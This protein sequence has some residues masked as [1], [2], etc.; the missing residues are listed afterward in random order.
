MEFTDDLAWLSVNFSQIADKSRRTQ[1]DMELTQ[2]QTH[3]VFDNSSSVAGPSRRGSRSKS[4]DHFAMSTPPTDRP[5]NGTPS[6]IEPDTR[7][8]DLNET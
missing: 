2:T 7:L 8:R 1:P 3:D 5:S 6:E 4:I